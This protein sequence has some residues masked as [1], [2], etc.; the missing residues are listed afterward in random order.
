M[1]KEQQAIGIKLVLAVVVVLL[2]TNTPHLEAETR[3]VVVDPSL[4][5]GRVHRLLFGDDYRD[6]WTTPIE[7]E[8][9]DFSREAGGLEALFRVGGAQ[10]FGLAL[11]GADG[12]AYTFRSLVKNLTQNLRA[13]LR[14]SPFGRAAQDQL[15]A[16]HPAAT[17]MVPPLAKA[18]GVLHNV[19][20]F[21]ILPDDPALGEFR[22]LFAGRIGT[23]EEFPTKAS[24]DYAGFNNATDIIKSEEFVTKWLASPEV[25][26]DADALVRVRLFDFFLGDWDRHANNYRWAKLPDKP[27]WQPLPEDRDQA[28][29]DFQGIIPAI[30]RPF[31]LRLLRFQNNYPS[32]FGL[33]NQGWPIHRWFLAGLDRDSWIETAIDLQNRITDDVIEEAI[34][35]MPKPYF[36]LS[37]AKLVS[38]LKARRDTLPAIAD[39]IYRHI[40]EEVDIQATDQSDHIDIRNSKQ[41]RLELTITSKSGGAPY[42]KRQF[43]PQE[44]K[45]LRLYL[46]AG[47]NTVDCHS[48]VNSKIKIDVVGSLDQDV[49]QGC[50]SANLR[51]TETEEIE[52]RKV[53]LRVPP[54]ALEKVA[55]ATENIPPEAARP[56]DWGSAS[57]PLYQAS[58]SS[59]EGFVLGYGRRFN[60][61][62]F[63]KTPFGQRH[64]V[65][66]SVSLGRSVFQV[67][68]NG[69]LQHWNPKLQSSLSANVSSIEQA[70]FFGFGNDTSDDGNSDFFETDQIRTTVG[71]DVSYLMT[72]DFDLFASVKL[73]YNSIDDDDNT[74]LNE[75][76]PFGVG[77]FGWANIAAGI[78]YDTRDQTAHKKPGLH[79]RLQAS[80]SP[81]IWDIDSTFGSID[82]EASGYFSLG[83]RSLLA[84]RVGGKNVA[85]TFPFQEAAYIGGISNVRGFDENRFAGDASVFG[86]AELRFS[87]GKDSSIMAESGYSAFVFGDVGRVFSDIDD[88][89]D[90][91]HPSVGAGISAAAV[92]RN[93]L[94][95]LSVA[96]SEDETNAI[97]NASF[98][99]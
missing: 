65:S 42:F 91:L 9:L 38:T 53:S 57:V 94:L 49:L 27:D 4:S 75:L 77:D 50:E 41:G 21:V 66:G 39:R 63:G 62:E 5:A 79:V 2:S 52:R 58:V 40:N 45:S 83:T 11:K 46:R 48:A 61:F 81:G 82:G 59:E 98:R 44:T 31:E 17:T 95:S 19:P 37:A 87:L 76:A 30:A 51:F 54:S 32:S 25:R 26:V 84:V 80:V 3:E 55:L 15:A 88:D 35:L 99:Y 89:S 13:D 60:L 29:V 10:T 22:E 67:G 74:L 73:N 72:P 23:I 24:D 1:L 96:R 7:I 12:K 18:A 33:T 92:S 85:G 68:Y 47:Q 56:R 36:E 28:F 86:S 14:S 8:V 71:P 20:K 93:F 6:L 34:N 43:N 64:D 97:L 16:I 69:M 70:D 78:E 90:S